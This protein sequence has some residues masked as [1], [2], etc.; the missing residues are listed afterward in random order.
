M[1]G[2]EFSNVCMTTHNYVYNKNNVFYSRCNATENIMADYGISN[3]IM[4]THD[5]AYNYI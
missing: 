3:V 5:I 1:K 2:Y 4:A